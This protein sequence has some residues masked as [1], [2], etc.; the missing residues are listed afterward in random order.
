MISWLPDPA[1]ATL[2]DALGVAGAALA[3]FLIGMAL[4]VG[5]ILIGGSRFR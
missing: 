5:V 2:A 4:V 1:T 3:C